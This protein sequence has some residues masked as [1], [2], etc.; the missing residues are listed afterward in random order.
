MTPTVL[1]KL[2]LMIHYGPYARLAGEWN[3]QIVPW[4][5]EWIQHTACIPHEVYRR[6]AKE[7]TA[8][9]FDAER[10]AAFAARNGYESICFTAKHH[11]GFCLFDTSVDDFKCSRDLVAELAAACARHKLGLSL[12]YSQAQDWSD[13]RAYR[14]YDPDSGKDFAGYFHEKCLPQVQEL[15]TNYGPIFSLWFDTPDRMSEEDVTYLR[16]TVKKLQPACL[17]SGRIGRGLGDY[18]VCQDNLLPSIPWSIPW[19]VP[20]SLY[21]SWGYKKGRPGALSAPEVLR[22]FLKT[23]ARGGHTL[24]N[25]GPKGDGS[26]PAEDL[27]LL[28]YV[29]QYAVEHALAVYDTVPAPLPLYEQEDWYLTHRP[30]EHLLF[31]HLPNAAAMSETRQNL[32]GY[33]GTLRGA[34]LVEDGRI[35]RPLDYLDRHTLEGEPC[36]TFTLPALDGPACIALDYKAA[37]KTLTVYDIQIQEGK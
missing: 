37:T 26:L 35:G 23:L 18:A 15:L 34:A 6:Y 2:G 9:R 28:S 27:E 24:L 33:N 29:G 31:L 14:A 13:P 30:D 10:I 5:S 22:I 21:D 25:L 19:E 17:I 32:I 16:Q 3:G 11:D 36:W 7:L 4:L 1:P 8:D 20:V 12:Y